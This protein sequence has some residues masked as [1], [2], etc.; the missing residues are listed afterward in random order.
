L[1]GSGWDLGTDRS[2]LQELC[3]YWA[4]EF[5]WRAFEGRFNRFPQF[6]TEI[7]G[8]RL[9]L[10]HARSPEPDA[11][12]LLMSHGWPGSVAEF[13]DVIGPLVDP[14]SHGG[15]PAHAFHVVAPSLPGYGFSGPTNRSGVNMTQIAAWFDALMVRLGYDRYG[16]QGGDWGS[17]ITILLGAN[18]ADHVLGIHVNML[19]P[20]APP[21]EQRAEGV[22]EEEWGWLDRARAFQANEAGYQ[23]IQSTKPQTLA[24]GLTDSPAGLAGWIVEKFRT[25]SDGGGDLETS[26]TKA[27]LLENISVYWLTGT[28]GS[29]VRLYH[30]AMGE[31]R[32]S[33]VAV[34]TGHA[35]FPGEVYRSPRAWADRVYDIM[36]WTVPERGGHFAAMEVPD[37][38]VDDVRAFFALDAVR[39]LLE[40]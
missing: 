27:R 11:V 24:Y 8:Q 34:P 38:F 36:H 39:S 4:D 1:P 5:D 7:D 37:A 19:P 9:H 26:Y 12:P 15:D 21:K 22:T 10:I 23:A 31:A 18:H 25:G 2:Y 14:R 3:R 13:L 40:G 20:T 30:E 29:S 16:A 17:M 6:V 32:P 35:S 28:I 33:R